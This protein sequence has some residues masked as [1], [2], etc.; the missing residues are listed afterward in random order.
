MYRPSLP[1]APT[2]QMRRRGDEDGGR[3]EGVESAVVS[4]T[5]TTMN[6]RAAQDNERFGMHGMHFCMP[7]PDPGF[8]WD[9]ARTFLAAV[10]GGSFSSAARAL[11]V[12]QPT[13]G[14]KVAALEEALG[15]ALVQRAGPGFVLSSAGEALV[16]HL[17]E[18]QASAARITRVAEARSLSLDGTV[19]ITAS[20]LISAHLLPRVIARLREAHPG[21]D[22]RVVATN[23]ARDL[24]K[25]EADVAVRNFKPTEPELYARKVGDRVARPYASPA[26]L[27]RLGNPTHVAEL[28]GAEYLAFERVDVM[29]THLER[30]GVPLGPRS[31]P[32]VTEDHLVQWELA[33]QGMGIC[34]AMEE[35]GD[36]EPAVRRVVPDFPLI[37]VP[38]WLVAHRELVTS[39]RIRVVFDLLAAEL[40]KASERKGTD[41]AADVARDAAP[42]AVPPKAARRASRARPRDA[43]R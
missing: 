20:Q 2:M 23:A 43:H 41:G 19:T 17:R 3:V 6:A 30:L 39:R 15:A 27:A 7:K 1:D 26:Y 22:V 13:V 10:E 14:R 18:M 34:F 36:C 12:A 40:A 25:R 37:P 29:R 11:G 4:F 31:F 32:I 28:V 16:V 9:L 8:D 24:Q 33:K 42:K 38:I 21:I 5:P 35:V